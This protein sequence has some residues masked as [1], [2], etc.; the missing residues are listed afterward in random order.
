MEL[1]VITTTSRRIAVR[2][3]YNE[4]CEIVEQAMID[5]GASPKAFNYIN[6]IEHPNAFR[7]LKNKATANEFAQIE[8]VRIYTDTIT[9]ISIM[10]I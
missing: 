9:D 1:T 8:P 3:K 4:I 2:G 5:A 7:Y 6:C 10:T